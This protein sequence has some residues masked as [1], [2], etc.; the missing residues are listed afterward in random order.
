MANDLEFAI[1]C[2]KREM[3]LTYKATYVMTLQDTLKRQTA[4]ATWFTGQ[5]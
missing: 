2:L 1:Y 3:L 4:T 5:P